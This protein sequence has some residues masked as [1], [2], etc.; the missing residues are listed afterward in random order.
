[1]ITLADQTVV[2]R[3]KF[4]FTLTIIRRFMTVFQAD[5]KESSSTDTDEC[6]DEVIQFFFRNH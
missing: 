5:S 1:M 3:K 4:E 6:A 2:H